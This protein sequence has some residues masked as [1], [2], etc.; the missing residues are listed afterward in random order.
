MPRTAVLP[1]LQA[2][3]ITTTGDVRDGGDGGTSSSNAAMAAC[4]TFFR[5]FG[6]TT[7]TASDSRGG[8]SQVGG[9]FAAG[10]KVLLK[11]SR[12]AQGKGISLHADLG[13]LAAAV[14]RPA[15][16]EGVC[17][18][19][20]SSVEEQREDLAMIGGEGARGGWVVQE[21]IEPLLVNK[22]KFDLRMYVLVASTKP[23]VLFWREGY[24][25]KAMQ[26]TSRRHD[27]RSRTRALS[28][29]V[30]GN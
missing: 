2:T 11:P 7:S 17:A 14:G 28:A 26:G 8:Q 4:T 22:V 16:V 15:S 9:A 3:E 13:S 25:R 18:P 10:R 29:G 19:D 6:L 30:H 23:L 27:H 1:K 24:A 21:Y 5:A 20:G 12:G